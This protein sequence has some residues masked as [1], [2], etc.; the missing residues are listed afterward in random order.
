[1]ARRHTRVGQGALGV[2]LRSKTV[3]RPET[4]PAM[5]HWRLAPPAFPAPHPVSGAKSPPIDS[6]QALIESD[7]API[8]SDQAVTGT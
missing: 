3:A 5:A 8:D 6:G 4:R 2:Y 1:M 7:S